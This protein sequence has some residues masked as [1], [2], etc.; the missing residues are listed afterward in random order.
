MEMS[1]DQRHHERRTAVTPGGAA[2]R[3]LI[4]LAVIMALP[5]SC[6]TTESEEPS[7]SPVDAAWLV[8]D[9]DGRGVIDRLQSTLQISDEGGEISAT[10]NGGCNRFFGTATVSGDEIEFGPLGS[11]RMACPAAIM[12]QEQ[13]FFAALGAT[14]S[15]RLDPGTRLLHFFDAAGKAV[16]RFSRMEEAR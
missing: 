10:G 1:A 4:A 15:F 11:T 2:L 12:D 8:E 3:W 16:L 7:G 6:T 14:R 13:A 5:V 9:I